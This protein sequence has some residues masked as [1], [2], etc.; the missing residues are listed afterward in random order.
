MARKYDPAYE[1]LKREFFLKKVYAALPYVLLGVIIVV[2]GTVL[3][4]W[5]DS[6]REQTLY[7]AEKKF[8]TLMN[9]QHPISEQ[10]IKTVAHVAGM[11]CVAA[12]SVPGAM[13]RIPSCVSPAVHTFLKINSALHTSNNDTELAQWNGPSSVW[14]PFAASHYAFCCVAKKSPPEQTSQAFTSLSKAGTM[15]GSN[16]VFSLLSKLCSVGLY[17]L[18]SVKPSAS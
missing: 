13:G 6:R 3:Y 16:N 5:M 1:E 7:Q 12:L 15:M 4:T 14:Y 18:P 8:D 2:G 11:E 10:D 9:S 17:T